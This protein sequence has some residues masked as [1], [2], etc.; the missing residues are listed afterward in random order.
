[1]RLIKLK[2]FLLTCC[3]LLLAS[4]FIFGQRQITGVVT[5]AENGETLIG[6]NIL[7]S[8]TSSGTIT[9]FDGT[10]SVTLPEGATQLEFSYTGYTTQILAVGVANVL[11]VKLVPGTALE[12]VVVIGYGTVK[13]EDATGAIQSV[14]SKDFNKGAITSAQQLVAGKVAGV[15]I[16]TDGDPGSG[17][18]IRIR[19]GSSLSASNDPLIIIDGVPVENAGVSGARNALNLVNPNDIESVS[20]LKDASATAIYGSRASN[21][22]IIITTKKGSSAQK[23]RVDYNGNVSISNPIDFLDVLSADEYRTL[24]NERY[25]EGHPARDLLGSAN[26]DWQEEI[27]QQAV[28]TDHNLSFSGALASVPY[29]LSVGYTNMK[30]VLKTEKFDRT[31]VALNLN[32]SFIDNRLQINF[33]VKSMF[34]NNRFANRGAI[35]SATSFDPTQPIFDDSS[36]YEGYFTWVD[37]NGVRNTLAPANPVALLNL[38]D[39]QSDV[40]RYI[41][42]GSVDYRFGFLPE[43]RA[44]LNLA[45]D[46]SKGEG[47]ID[48]PGTASFAFDPA[49]GGGVKNT[50][51]ATRK[52]EL[53]EFYLNYVKEFGIS[54]VDLM[55]GYSWQRF[56]NESS[57]FN[58]NINGTETQE[59]EDSGELF[60]LSVFGRLNYALK[61]RYLFTFTVRRDGTSRFSP[62]SRWG[63]FPAGAFAVKIIDNEAATLSALKVRV[64]YGI[65]GQQDVG[66]FYGYLPR[67]Q[68]SFNDARYQFGDTYYTT[69]R[70]NGYNANLKWEETTTYNAGIDFGILNG[71]ISGSLDYYLRKTEDL[72]N[73]VRIP[74]GT[75]LTNFI[76][77]NVGSLENTGVELAL[78]FTPIQKEDLVW[79]LSVNAAYN[80]NE[81]TNLTA[82]DDPTYIGIQTGGISGGVGNNIQVHSVGFPASSFFVNEQ[83]YDNNGVPVEG[84]YVD[85]NG[86]GIVNTEDQYR[87]EKPA[88]DWIFGLYTSVNYKDFTLSLSGRANVGNYVYN[89]VQSNNSLN[90]LY[91]STN[92]LLNVN[93]ET[94][95]LDIEV[96]QLFSDHFIQEGSFFR[97]DHITAA[98][99]FSGL[100]E[101]FNLAISASVQNPVL[102]T[103]YSGLDPERSNGIDGNIYPRSRIW[104]FGASLSF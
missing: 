44:N 11:D 24:I 63:V 13:R 81:I 28:G 50:Y 51:S 49:T 54:K 43:L 53:L 5:D 103:D 39:D 36:V 57:F 4:S 7:V 71:R 87:L 82:S 64:G 96:S 34:N 94:P 12:E 1:M 33:G 60:L 75:N 25:E 79:D 38:R 55:A 89:N 70:P 97:L 80:E 17:A 23:L 56:F 9:D 8:G 104:V 90:S 62:D 27:Y 92:Y 45:Y 61:E 77:S 76:D 58:S 30:G 6:V 2:P 83:V 3:G 41:I 40:Q 66:G 74:A 26:T 32:P 78:N 69:L 88:P 15:Q 102:I 29:R 48:V 95:A 72:L 14:S 10:Y 42:N 37:A 47:T 35:G 31:T 98:Y 46:Y 99:N 22:V 93:K 68:A 59:G 18:Q 101:K 86:D 84:L 65:T 85:R 20:V 21:G 67:Y 19:G 52:N 91:A 73:F 16:T 100:S